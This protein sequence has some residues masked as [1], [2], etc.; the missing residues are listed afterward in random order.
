[1]LA[2]SAVM[3]RSHRLVS[4]LLSALTA[5]A[6]LLFGAVR[7][8]SPIETLVDESHS[9]VG[10][11][12]LTTVD[13]AVDVFGARHAL[14]ARDSLTL[15]VVLDV[16]CASCRRNAKDYLALTRWA[17]TEGIASRLLVTNDRS[18]AA[19]FGRLAGNDSAVM[20]ASEGLVLDRLR[21][22]V[23]P[24]S[25]LV[26]SGG[27]IRGRWLAFVPRH[28]ELLNLLGRLR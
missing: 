14:V 24:S 27:V 23:S 9:Q 11:R 15:L 6:I 22:V 17:A 25:L 4:A 13:S 3:P 16:H 10:L 12:A 2:T 19:Q 26:D 18:S 21:L 1:M 28:L 7:L 8:G 20:I 5:L